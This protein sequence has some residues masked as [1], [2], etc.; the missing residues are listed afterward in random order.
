M[1]TGAIKS[2]TNNS[3]A[4]KSGSQQFS[5][6]VAQANSK[7]PVPNGG[8]YGPKIVGPKI[9]GPKI[10]GEG[11]VGPKLVGPKLV[12]PKVVGT[13]APG[14][15][16]AGPALVG[17]KRVGPGKVGPK[18]VGQGIVGPRLVGPGIVGPK[19]VGPKKPP[20]TLETTYRETQSKPGRIFEGPKGPQLEIGAKSSQRVGGIGVSAEKAPSWEVSAG[21]NTQLGKAGVGLKS[22]TNMG[23]GTVS[24][25]NA[26]SNLLSRVGN[27]INEMKDRTIGK[28]Y[29]GS[30]TSTELVVKG[31]VF[32]GGKAKFGSKGVEAT[33]VAA[34]INGKAELSTKRTARTAI[35][36][37]SAGASGDVK[38]AL[39]VGGY[40]TP[41]SST[42]NI[43]PG[44]Y[45]KKPTVNITGLD[46]KL[47]PQVK[48]SPPGFG[49]LL[50][51]GQAANS[52]LAR[53][54]QSNFNVSNGGQV[55]LRVPDGLKV[56][57]G[58]A[59]GKDATVIDAFGQGKVAGQRNPLDKAFGGRYVRVTDVGRWVRNIGKQNVGNPKY[60][61]LRQVSDQRLVA[62]NKDKIVTVKVNGVPTQVISQENVRTGLY[63]DKNNNLQVADQVKTSFGTVKLK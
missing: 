52:G 40:A 15:T 56:F 45:A 10:V 12:G 1:S 5:G 3:S 34:E 53:K 51:G 13:G 63:F 22:S 19:I 44:L 28:F 55:S 57:Q 24:R 30:D 42:W 47:Q 16:P 26:N 4:N 33:V 23:E 27:G 14:S 38:A 61:A 2:P 46:V 29:K 31:D 25:G 39:G 7:K 11:K 41:S 9:V 48:K 49:D 20:V 37:V 35:G 32:S 58:P 62:L 50:A 36:N 60:D 8:V 17:P 54:I 6:S 43:A 21:F 18:I 59:N